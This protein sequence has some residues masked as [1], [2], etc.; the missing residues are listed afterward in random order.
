MEQKKIKKVNVPYLLASIFGPIIALVLVIV[1]M[2]VIP[3]VEVATVI[4][5]VVFV[6]SCIWWGMGPKRLY[7]KKKEEKLKE[8]DAS[9]FVRN[10]TFNADGCTVAVD[11]VHGKIAMV[12]MWNPSECY[13]LPANRITRMWVDDGKAVTGTSRVSFLFIVDDVKVRVNTFTSN[14]TWSMNSNYV[15]EAISKADMMI[16]SL[17]A[18]YAAAQGEQNGNI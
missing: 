8:L 6:A 2:A 7:L 13:V 14:R 9:G 15:L 12:F 10:H 4:F 16:E 18:A 11:V 5:M 1:L 17:K 3:V